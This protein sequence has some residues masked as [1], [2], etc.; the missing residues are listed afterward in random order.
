M[1]NKK[2]KRLINLIYN[3]FNIQKAVRKNQQLKRQMNSGHEQSS[4]RCKANE[5][6]MMPNSALLM[7]IQIKNHEK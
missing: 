6:Y 4:Q 1:N 7:K 3:I 5:T 2:E